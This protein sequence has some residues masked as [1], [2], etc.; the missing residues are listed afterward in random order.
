[1]PGITMRDWLLSR[2]K[3]LWENDKKIPLDLYSDLMELGV[4]VHTVLQEWEHGR[5]EDNEEDLEELEED[6]LASFSLEFPESH[7]Y[8][9]AVQ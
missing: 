9:D 1:M 2:M 8:G 6:V 7:D 5:A 4:D 3:T